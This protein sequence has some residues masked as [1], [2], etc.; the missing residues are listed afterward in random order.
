M[1]T[2]AHPGGF[3][4]VALGGTGSDRPRSRRR[5]FVWRLFRWAGGALGLLFVF[6]VAVVG[7]VLLHLDTP[8]ARSLAVRE[9]NATLAPMFLGHVRLDSLGGLGLGGVRG[10]DATVEDRSG[11][12]VI[13]AHGVSV[14]MATLTLLRSLLG[15][16]PSPLTVHVYSASIDD[17]NVVLDH[18]ANGNLLIAN[19]FAPAHPKEPSPPNPNPRRLRIMVDRFSL[20]H[21]RAQRAL[22]GGRALDVSG[23]LE[24]RLDQGAQAD[25]I[26]DAMLKWDG[27]V[28]AIATSMHAS[29]NEQRVDAVVDVPPFAAS[30]LRALL[31][32]SPLER[33]GSAHVEVHGPISNVQAK[34][35]VDADEAAL[36]G[37]ASYVGFHTAAVSHGAADLTV[38]QGKL[39]ETWIPDA[40]L[41]GTASLRGSALVR[42]LADL[43]IEEPGAPTRVTLQASPRGGGQPVVDFEV[44]SSS[45]DLTRVPQLVPPVR[46]SYRLSFAGR[47]DPS[48]RTIEGDLRAS[49]RG[50]SRGSA[51]VD[52]ATIDAR[53][54]GALGDPIVFAS[55]RAGGLH[56]GNTKIDAAEV[57]AYGPAMSPHVVLAARASTL[58]S[59]EGS[60]D[61]E[62]GHGIVLSSLRLA[63]AHAGQ[64]ATVAARRIELGGARGGGIR[65]DDARVD[66]M[67]K[68][69]LGSA[70]V[71]PSDI[72]LRV[73]S[74][75][76]DLARIARLAHIEKNLGA[77]TLGLDADVH[78]GPRR[79]E[80][81][82]RL[83]LQCA[84]IGEA[85]DVDAHISGSVDGRHVAA[86][87]RAS[88]RE[89][90]TFALNAPAVHL[91]RDDTRSIAAWRDAWGD[92]TF[93]ADVNL[94]RVAA[95]V[96][97]EDL[98][99]SEARGRIV[100][101]GHVERDDGHDF[102]PD[103]GLSLHT[104]DLV[105]APRTPMRRDIDYVWV[106]PKPP[107]RL[108]GV[109]LDVDAHVDGQS[110]A[111]QLMIRARDAKS[112]IAQLDVSAP[113]ASFEDFYGDK[114]TR[115]ERLLRTPVQAHLTMPERGLWTLPP[116]LQ[117][118]FLTGSAQADVRVSGTA[119]APHVDARAT[120][121][122]SRFQADVTA[123]PIDVELG[124]RY[125]G[126]R[127]DVT[128][129]GLS[130][131]QEVL[132]L[133]SIVNASVA[134]LLEH[135]RAPFAWSADTKAHF[136]GFPLQSIPVLDDKLIAGA[137]RGDLE[138]SGLHRDANARADLTVDDLRIGGVPYRSATVHASADGRG[139][140]ANLRID[141]SDG[142]LQANA[143][144]AATWGASL[145]PT[146]D[147]NRPLD[148]SL[149]AK[150]FRMGG[151]EPMM[152][153]VLDELDGRLDG[154]VVVQLDPRTRSARMAGG[155]LFYDGRFQASAGGGEFH[156]VQATVSLTPDGVIALSKLTA[157]GVTGRLEATGSAQMRGTRLESARAS[158][159]IPSNAPIPLSASGVE[160][161]NVDGRFDIT[162]TTRGDTMDVQVK[163]PQ[164]RVALPVKSGGRAQA[165]GPMKNVSI[166]AHR[167][168]AA[169]LVTFP[170]DP[171][172]RKKVPE[173][174][175]EAQAQSGQ[176]S[177]AV[178]LDEVRVLRGKDLRVSLGGKLKVD[179][180]SGAQ[181]GPAVTGQIN[182]KPGGRL[183]VQGKTFTVEH[184][185][186]SFVDDPS[187]P[188]I[189][190][191]ASYQAQDGTLVYAD[192][193]GPLKTGKVTLSSE[194]PL[195]RQE[196][197]ELLLFGTT[198][199]PQ[200]QTP[201]GTPAT[202]ALTT[203]G[204]EATQPINHMLDQIG[205][206]AVTAKVGSTAAGTAAPEI[207]V[208]IAKD[209]S[210]QIAVVL[211]QPPPGVNP[212]HT[213]LT[214]DW[215]FAS[216]WSLA[217]T[218]GD[219]G[220]TIFDLLWRKRY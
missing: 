85:H 89:L 21:V 135:K 188:Q 114:R 214:L 167:G 121:R 192:F 55:V 18:D 133:K 181:A 1:T 122:G 54:H 99:L 124:A 27:S 143:R 5:P 19:A 126:E 23:A 63:L 69:L 17:A 25:A 183:S 90:G 207:E 142:F 80:G 78:V 79:A 137:V 118:S 125:D 60:T 189:V 180:S 49:A 41:L 87:V 136:E 208:Q 106:S 159:V 206:G 16:P 109:D 138:L 52:D 77:G 94:G 93:D 75:G 26:P 215:R 150:A 40:S 111:T 175:A 129:R 165:L 193:I 58:P 170:L 3:A 76:L 66:G 120:L 216:K 119:L 53:A 82:L 128:V 134:P 213:L 86:V 103:V 171:E 91:A 130:K 204:G 162:E 113:S 127:A 43:T 56:A 199:G 83:D 97:R 190:V 73:T 205:L 115:T 38:H 65:V 184:G 62:L 100:A 64:L 185:T 153:G 70:T 35:H 146:L 156:G 46:G 176:I 44:D 42:A 139:V 2:G 81:R 187:N 29:V 105:L 160:V 107:W 101:R 172:K 92:V 169:K 88:A 178:N 8:R 9:V 6:L 218:V 45:T 147:P 22:P 34:L 209:I 149:G 12:P 195:P 14:H 174:R 28:G 198:S 51:G 186:V 31:P 37:N 39:G 59:V 161:G 4:G 132:N 219:A 200:P 68:P 154:N 96:P 10:V 144:A 116:S 30:A 168:D 157:L 33:R 123:V 163:V 164:A 152:Q 47:L 95:L 61:V 182:L 194:P 158:I 102:T 11:R 20:T 148:A 84:V 32:G 210:V 191:R 104:Q 155:L 145:A 74:D 15:R 98:P 202:Q 196:I 173:G 197:V 131:D 179:T 217:S 166:G 141:Q 48:D 24:A 211:G 36:D 67:G 117:Q 13:V 201:E 7:G 140:D 110:G 151:L 108:V 212:D 72:E 220:T 57:T 71:T 112:E 50:V 177:L 203:V